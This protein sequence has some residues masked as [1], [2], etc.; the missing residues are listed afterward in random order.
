MVTVSDLILHS[1]SGLVNSLKELKMARRFLRICG[2]PVALLWGGSGVL[3]H[4]VKQVYPKE[5]KRKRIEGTVQIKTL[6][7][8]TGEPRDFEIVSGDRS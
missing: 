3:V 1:A 7:S 4:Y 8:K 5:A 6:V 2:I